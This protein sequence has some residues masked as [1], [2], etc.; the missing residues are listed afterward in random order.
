MNLQKCEKRK[1]VKEMAMD[2]L[3]KMMKN[4]GMSNKEMARIIGIDESTLYRK[5]NKEGDG[6]TIS[7]ANK[8]VDALG[9]NN[10][11]ALLIFFKKKLA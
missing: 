6:F 11:D 5:M 10:E 7:E 9:M 2:E 3:K 1:E 4:A 8:I